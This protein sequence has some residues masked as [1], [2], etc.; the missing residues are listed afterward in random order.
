L[1]RRGRRR[2]DAH[3]VHR[4]DAD[5]GHGA[6]RCGILS[7]VVNTWDVHTRRLVQVVEVYGWHEVQ[8]GTFLS[9]RAGTQ[10]VEDV[11]IALRIV[12]SHDSRALQKVSPHC[13]AHNSPLLV[14]LDLCELPKTGRV[15][16]SDCLGIAKRLQQRVRL[17][18]LALNARAGRSERATLSIT[19]QESTPCRQHVVACATG[20]A[21]RGS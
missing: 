3:L 12:H 16:I 18:H 10:L 20:T 17:E 15:G 11:V 6:A 7:G 1:I 21:K 2:V 9:T 14:K 19:T 4:W 13:C 5:D 8:A